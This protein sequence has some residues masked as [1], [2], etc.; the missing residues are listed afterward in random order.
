[1]TTPIILDTDIGGDV[2]DALC[3]ALALAA[4][5]LELVAVTSV[6][7][8]S[9]LRA[10]VAKKLC[11]LAGR[12][13]IPVYAGC[14]VPVLGGSG[15]GALGHEGEGILEP[16][17][18]P[19]IE[20]EHA[21]LAIGRLLRERDG[22]ELVL[23]GPLTN[24]AV[25]LM[26]DP[27]L[28]GRTR[29]L[30]VMG[31]HI[32]RVEYG[33]HVFAPGIDYNLC[34]DPH[35]SA[36]VLNAGFP[37]RL[38]TADVTLQTWIRGEDLERIEKSDQP[39]HAALARAIRGWTPI[40]RRIF[41]SAGCDMSGDNVAFL[42]DPLALACVY[43]DS[44]CRFEELEIETAIVDGTLRTLER[45]RGSDAT[46]PTRC[47]LEVDAERFRRHFLER[48]LGLADVR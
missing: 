13:E 22:L 30:S 38:V 33:G 28:V 2:D 26:L 24:V 23:I 4:P 19:E 45:T 18:E 31:G 14:R 5:E 39:L 6:G 7:G 40:Q 25:A 35:A 10:R 44:F 29:R 16:G 27:D 15:F 48:L 1:M 9:R 46:V 37:T 21:A 3:L 32:R 11:E 20:A 42:H 8:E 43:D 47:A 36:L 34:S 12:P 41:G 17:E